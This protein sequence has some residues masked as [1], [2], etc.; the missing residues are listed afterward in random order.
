MALGPWGQGELVHVRATGQACHQE[1]D[2]KSWPQPF[3]V[4]VGGTVQQCQVAVWLSMAWRTAGTSLAA[5]LLA[6][7][8]GEPRALYC[9]WE[10]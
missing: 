4:S 2:R 1:C 5:L 10:Y 3:C 6:K 8:M 9:Y 7:K